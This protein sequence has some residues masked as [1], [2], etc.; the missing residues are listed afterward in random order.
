MKSIIAYLLA[1]TMMATIASQA[2][3]PAVA[4]MDAQSSVS[5]VQVQTGSE[6]EAGEPASQQPD[7]TDPETVVTEE[8]ASSEAV[9][10]ESIS[11][12]AASEEN[13]SNEAASEE[14]VSSET[15]SSE[16]AS[17][18]LA[19]SE[20]VLEENALEMQEE[21]ELLDE[22]EEPTETEPNGGVS[23]VI[24]AAMVMGKNVDF[25]M[26]LYR[27]GEEMPVAQVNGQLTENKEGQASRLK[28]SETGLEPGS[29]QVVITAPG[30]ATYTQSLEVSRNMYSELTLYTDDLAGYGSTAHPGVL[31]V[32]DANGD[33]VLNGDDA[34]TIV[35]AIENGVQGGLADLNGSGEVDLADLQLLA[36]NLTGEE[37]QVGD[38]YSTVQTRVA[39]NVAN[40][41]VSDEIAVTGSLK[42][43]VNENGG[44]TLGN[45]DGT[46]ISEKPIVVDF[47]FVGDDQDVTA[48][49]L[50]KMDGMTIQAPANSEG[51]V[52]AGTILVTYVDEN[53]REGT[54]PVEIQEE[55]A[56]GIALFSLFTT[57]ATATR[58]ADGTL[59]IN[60]GKQ[61]AVKKITLTI[62]A[63]QSN[64]LAE[65]S[66]VEFL[67][68]M[69][70]RI[71]EPEMS[72]PEGLSG[73]VPIRRSC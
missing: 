30:F 62:T 41:V 26:T 9:S 5:V 38:V 10:E 34:D 46:S 61:V 44:V 39:D 73:P 48:E 3:L 1:F 63:T 66:K 56:R 50:P 55:K 47:N 68:G 70:N 8:P 59:E 35:N 49:E 71:P 20:L 23:V 33:G 31:R 51:A 37:A 16:A 54:I 12:E 17:E 7:E 64:N 6:K 43:L 32:G 19:S 60:F 14:S 45:E 58:K 28:L 24:N 21:P 2:L 67:N 25:V 22:V 36:D 42:D 72:I 29:Y 4:A 13:T 53:G 57:S 52:T 11:S 18:E 65:I 69:E 27:N 40:P 15:A